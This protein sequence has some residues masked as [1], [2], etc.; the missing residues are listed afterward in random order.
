M[1]TTKINKIEITEDTTYFYD[2]Q[3]D[4]DDYNKQTFYLDGFEIHNCFIITGK[5]RYAAK[6][7]DNEYVR[8]KEP[9]YKI[10]GLT[11]IATTCPVVCKASLK[12][13]VIMMLNGANNADIT[14]HNNEFK[15]TFFAQKAED[16]SIP[17]GT[18]GVNKYIL[19]D[20]F[21]P[22][23]PIQSR[24]AV[25]FNWAVEKNGL[26]AEYPLIREGDKL[27]YCYLKTPNPS[28]QNVIGY[29]SKLPVEFGLHSYIDYDTMYEKTYMAQM[30]SLMNAMKWVVKDKGMLDW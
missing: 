13:A 18:S 5:K 4:Q 23:T 30:T 27:K 24:A 17:K 11:I 19:G 9:E 29:I 28:Q 15:K 25:L 22:S 2:L 10:V 1:N 12:K 26:G 7:L 3:L 20:G 6:V 21:I 16:I 14:A 8:Y